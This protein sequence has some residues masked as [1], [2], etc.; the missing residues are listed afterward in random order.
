MTQSRWKS[1]IFWSG[2]ATAVLALLV[3]L[4][5]INLEQS[6]AFKGVVEAICSAWSIFSMANNPTNKTG[7]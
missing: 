1:P 2:V 3:S 6:Q 5:V 4:Q 7:F